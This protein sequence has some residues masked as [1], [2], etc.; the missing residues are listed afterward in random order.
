MHIFDP[1]NATKSNLFGKGVKTF[2]GK[3]FFLVWGCGQNVG[4]FYDTETYNLFLA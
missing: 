4:L 3:Q 2:Y 1:G